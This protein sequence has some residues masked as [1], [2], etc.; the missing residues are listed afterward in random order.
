[1]NITT[2]E[3]V[4]RR[5]SNLNTGRNNMKKLAGIVIASFML[6]SSITAW[7]S[8]EALPKD[9]DSYTYT[10]SFVIP[11][12][13]SPLF[14]FFHYSMNETGLAAFKK[15]G[16]YPDGAII[17]GKV[18]EVV[19]SP[20]GGMV[21]GKRLRYSYMRKDQSAKETGGWIFAAFSRDGK[22]VQKD[23]KTACFACHLAARDSG[24]VF[25]KPLE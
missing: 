7:A 8:E 11:D 24:Y 20:V 1:M 17:V 21:E 10:G 14:G 4:R 15:G 19:T 6:A 25:S 3:E 13:S 12:K 9:L 23:V 16:P 2:A 22:F 5:L 18:Y